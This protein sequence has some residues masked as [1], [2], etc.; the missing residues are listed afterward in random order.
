MVLSRITMA[1][2][3]L[4]AAVAGSAAAQGKPDTLQRLESMRSTGGPMT[5]ETVP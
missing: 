3:L 5:L 4:A 1:I 2:A